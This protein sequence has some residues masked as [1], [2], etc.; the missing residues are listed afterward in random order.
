MGAGPGKIFKL[1]HIALHCIAVKAFCKK[2]SRVA[3]LNAVQRAAV[4]APNALQ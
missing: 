4:V 2:C 1:L 3:A